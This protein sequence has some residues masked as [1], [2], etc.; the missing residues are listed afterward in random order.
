MLQIIF[1]CSNNWDIIFHF[2]SCIW[3]ASGWVALGTLK[4]KRNKL[5]WDVT[6]YV[7]A[8]EWM[9]KICISFLQHCIRHM[10]NH[11]RWFLF[12]KS[13]MPNTQ[14]KGTCRQSDS[15]SPREQEH[16]HFWGCHYW[17]LK[18][19]LKFSEGLPVSNA[20]LNQAWWQPE[21]PATSVSLSTFRD[22]GGTGN[23]I[24][25]WEP[26]IALPLILPSFSQSVFAREAKSR[27]PRWITDDFSIFPRSSFFLIVFWL[28]LRWVYLPAGRQKCLQGNCEKGAPEGAFPAQMEM[29]SVFSPTGDP[30]GQEM[31][32]SSV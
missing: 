5:L 23:M 26:Q 24:W 16:S 25:G 7:F 13:V 17:Y 1:K 8:H 11:A 29:T 21:V 19:D 3:C 32:R 28:G 20:K 15:C 6:A 18:S 27:C 22:Q 12:K 10:V 14:L 2:S 4:I 31:L 9:A 30:W